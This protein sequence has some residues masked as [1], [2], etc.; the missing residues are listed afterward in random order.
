MNVEKNLFILKIL[1]SENGFLVGTYSPL[2]MTKYG[3]KS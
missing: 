3:R 2:G 1:E